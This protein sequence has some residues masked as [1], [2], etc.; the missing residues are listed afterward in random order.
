MMKQY[1]QLD[2]MP[3]YKG[4]NPDKYAEANRKLGLSSC[5]GGLGRDQ[6]HLST[7]LRRI[8]GTCISTRD[9]ESLLLLRSLGNRWGTHLSLSLQTINGVTVLQ[10]TDTLLTGGGGGLVLKYIGDYP[11]VVM[12]NELP[13]MCGGA[14][15]YVSSARSM[16]VTDVR[17]CCDSGLWGGINGHTYDEYR[18]EYSVDG[19]KGQLVIQFA[20]NMSTAS[21]QRFLDRLLEDIGRDARGPSNPD[22]I[23]PEASMVQWIRPQ[24]CVV[25]T[26]YND[27]LE[28][29]WHHNDGTDAETIL[30]HVIYPRTGQYNI[31]P[32]QDLLK[33]SEQRTAAEKVV[34]LTGFNL[35][36]GRNSIGTKIGTLFNKLAGPQLMERAMPYLNEGDCIVI[37]DNM[38]EASPFSVRTRHV[39]EWLSTEPKCIQDYAEQWM[40]CRGYMSGDR[41]P[42]SCIK[43]TGLYTASN[44]NEGAHN[45]MGV[46]LS[47]KQ[48]QGGL[49]DDCTV[50][51]HDL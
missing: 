10:D 20:D 9:M 31:P 47:M 21:M 51:H 1:K 8:G 42:A 30:E 12:G 26:R 5:A 46:V 37:T 2:V 41:I 36:M 19:A 50:L 35:D 15:L 13:T 48:S 25:T 11:Y 6:Y 32:T 7:L 28:D 27:T 38:Q 34:A 49:S 23:R 44:P 29:Y 16:A 17:R 14:C 24:I 33:F 45:I 22:C 3:S 4:A 39:I 43:V 40:K 18:D